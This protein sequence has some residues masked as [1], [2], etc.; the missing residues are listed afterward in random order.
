MQLRV[1]RRAGNNDTGLNT[2]REQ[3]SSR[4]S[5]YSKRVSDWASESMTLLCGNI[6]GY[7]AG[8]G[9]QPCS[10]ARPGSHFSSPNDFGNSD[11]LRNTRNPIEE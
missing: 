2:E 5:A 10:I 3:R 8:N 11:D 9:V 4:P 7:H 1:T 6:Q